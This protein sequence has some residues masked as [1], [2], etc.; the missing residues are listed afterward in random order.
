MAKQVCGRREYMETLIPTAAA[1]AVAAL[2]SRYIP[3]LLF[4]GGAEF[5]NLVSTEAS[6]EAG[7]AEKTSTMSTKNVVDAIKVCKNYRRFSVPP[8]RAFVMPG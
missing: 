4:H 3:M 7:D 6:I 5:V 2:F 1:A 8:L